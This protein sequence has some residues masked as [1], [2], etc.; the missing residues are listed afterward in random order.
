MDSD[1]RDKFTSGT[2]ADVTAGNAC[3]ETPPLLFEKMN[4]DFGPFDIDLTADAQRHLLPKWFGP[5]SPCGEP[6]AIE[7]YWP[8][9]GR[10]GMSNPPYGP[11]TQALIA[12]AR[13]MAAEGF[14]STL[15][16]PMRVTAAFK[17]HVLTGASELLFCDARIPFFENGLPRLN[18]TTW[19]KKGKAVADA[20]LF[21]SIIV[22]FLPQLKDTNPSPPRLGVYELPVCVTKD[23]LDRAVAARTTR[24]VRPMPFSAGHALKRVAEGISP[25]GIVLDFEDHTPEPN[26]IKALDDIQKLP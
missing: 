23:D 11:F 5:D 17:E 1:T 16:L 3:W 15:L 2:N 7:A 18:E 25:S 8:A 20:A 24:A 22:R 9:H 4:R 12:W 21:D 19:T 10:S 26:L 6:D 14:A 13:A